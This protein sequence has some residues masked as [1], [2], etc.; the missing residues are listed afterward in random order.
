MVSRRR[1]DAILRIP[2][3]V[4]PSGYAVAAGWFPVADGWQI[5]AETRIHK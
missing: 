2:R 5:P 4:L 1:A 3:A